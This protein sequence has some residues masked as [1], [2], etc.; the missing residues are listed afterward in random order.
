[1][2]DLNKLWKI[3]KDKFTD[4]GLT[5]GA[6]SAPGRVNLIGEHTDYNEGFVLPMAIEKEVEKIDLDYQEVL[7]IFKSI[8]L[9]QIDIIKGKILFKNQ[10]KVIVE[11]EDDKVVFNA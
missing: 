5:K 10:E 9:K 2:Q 3:F 7:E 11:S 4:T 6:F 1:M 8:G